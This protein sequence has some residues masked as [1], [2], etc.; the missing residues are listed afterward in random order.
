MERE[1][2]RVYL[3]GSICLS[4]GDAL[5]TERSLP[6]RQGRLLFAMLAAER[7]RA[8]SKEEL[9][10][11][12]WPEEP[13]AAW[14][15]AVRSLVSK[16][17]AA[18]AEVGLDGT[19]SLAQAFG[20]YQL[21]LPED[22]W[23]DLEASADAVHRAESALREGDVETANGWA[24]VANAIAR[25][26]FLSGEEGAWAS[27]RRAWLQDV[28]L[29]ALECRSSCALTRGLYAL[30]AGDAEIVLELE[31]FRE[32]AFRLLMRAR[33]GEGNPGE[34]LRQYERCRTLLAEELGAAPS[35]ET[36]ALHL[37]IL[38]SV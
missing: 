14:D 33:V 1:P 23:V 25:R 36:E 10:Y 34:A 7:E 12:L 13:P 30:A 15:V 37:Q 3:A 16:I 20:C 21:R 17:R 5:L 19:K 28:R 38:R 32:S 8:W 2:V 31:P 26:P 18:L 35:D 11:A 27:R 4:A 9:A 22:A 24:L 6:G 29:R